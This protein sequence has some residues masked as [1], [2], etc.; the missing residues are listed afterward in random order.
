MES[1]R[2]AADD[3]DA[4]E[5]PRADRFRHLPPPPATPD[6]PL[7]F[8]G[9]FLSDSHR[10]HACLQLLPHSDR[11]PPAP[12]M[13]IHLSPPSLLPQTC[14]IHTVPLCPALSSIPLYLPFERQNK[15]ITRQRSARTH[16]RTRTRRRHTA[17]PSQAMRSQEEPRT[18]YR[19][20]ARRRTS[21]MRGRHLPGRRHCA[22]AHPPSEIHHDEQAAHT[23]SSY[24]QIPLPQSQALP[25]QLGIPM[26]TP[27]LVRPERCE[28][29]GSFSFPSFRPICY[30]NL[31]PTAPTVRAATATSQNMHRRLDLPPLAFVRGRAPRPCPSPPVSHRYPNIHHLKPTPSHTNR[32][33]H[34]KAGNNSSRDAIGLAPSIAPR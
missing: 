25:L 1:L 21:G 16:A 18:R 4:R 30:T 11:L 13:L 3:S 12:R 32:P 22:A 27:L 19:P 9:H 17:T 26:G 15:K 8:S 28:S 33:P 6:R 10:P 7:S 2:S 20:K 24:L 34:T 5:G 14:Y 31:P 29:L 23:R